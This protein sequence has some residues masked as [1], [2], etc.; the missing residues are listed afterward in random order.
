[1]PTRRSIIIWVMTT[2]FHIL[3]NTFV[4]NSIVRRCV[5]YNGLLKASINYINKINLDAI[6]TWMVKVH[7]LFSLLTYSMGQSPSWEANRFSASQEICHILWN[8]KVH[9]SMYKC[10]PPIPLLTPINLVHAPPPIPLPQDPSSLISLKHGK[11]H[12]FPSD[13]V[14]A[15]N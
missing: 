8:P 3:S 5:G 6:C 12:Q 10:P 14:V 11:R 7:S 13:G 15:L 9:Y 4:T 2:A 1:M